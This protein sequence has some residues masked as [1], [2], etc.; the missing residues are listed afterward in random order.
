M[1]VPFL[2]ELRVLLDWLCVP[3]SLEWF[4]W[5][6]IEDVTGALFRR[7]CLLASDEVCNLC[8]LVLCLGPLQERECLS[9][10]RARCIK[11]IALVLVL[12]VNTEGQAQ[13]RPEAGRLVPL[14]H[15]LPAHRFDRTRYHAAAHLFVC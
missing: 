13:E 5:L 3:T 10:R 11:C 8:L 2:F 4:Q 12:F 7:K 1:F 15:R 9:T 14:G 6:Q